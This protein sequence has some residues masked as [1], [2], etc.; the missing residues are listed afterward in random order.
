MAANY[1][2]V[3]ITAPTDSV[4]QLNEVVKG[5]PHAGV[6]ELIN[7]LPKVLAGSKDYKVDVYTTNSEPSL[8]AGSG[9]TSGSYDMR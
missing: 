4:A 8:S 9:G 2:A 1:I 3:K 6:Q 5:T 7:L